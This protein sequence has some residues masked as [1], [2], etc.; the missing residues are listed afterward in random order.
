M[1]GQQPRLDS[2]NLSYL[3]DTMSREALEFKKCKTYANQFTDQVL[4]DMANQM[5][6][7]HAGQYSALLGY[8]N[9]HN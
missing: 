1:F 5:A 2:K 9:A 4:T 7:H 8:L 6:D 3:E